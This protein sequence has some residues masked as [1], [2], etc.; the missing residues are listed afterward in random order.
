MMK[1][2]T[3]KIQQ[4]IEDTYL[5]GIHCIGRGCCCCLPVGDRAD[6]VTAI[7]ALFESTHPSSFDV[8]LQA[9]NFSNCT[10]YG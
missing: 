3:S 1:R 5:V 6:D 4:S 2:Y 10:S 7:R 9:T 8:S